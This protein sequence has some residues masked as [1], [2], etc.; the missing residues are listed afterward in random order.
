MAMQMTCLCGYVF[1]AADADEFWDLAQAH[2]AAAHPD[3]V[4]MATR[5]DIIALAELV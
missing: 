5:E 2:I 1:R 4:G 3:Q